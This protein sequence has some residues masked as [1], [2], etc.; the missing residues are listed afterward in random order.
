MGIFGKWAKLSSRVEASDSSDVGWQRCWRLYLLMPRAPVEGTRCSRWFV[1]A[2]SGLYRIVQNWNAGS[3]IPI[4]INFI[5]T[6][7]ETMPLSFSWLCDYL[8][9]KC[10]WKYPNI[11]IIFYNLLESVKNLWSSKKWFSTI[12][13]RCKP[14]GKWGVIVEFHL[15]FLCFE[16]WRKKVISNTNFDDL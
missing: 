8:K 3:G 1:M 9:F 4:S 6:A 12:A 13:Q 15:S 10:I 7:M 5:I 16:F 11:S 2:F 14:R